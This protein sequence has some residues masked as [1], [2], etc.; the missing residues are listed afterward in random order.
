MGRDD[1]LEQQQWPVRQ[2]AAERV[3]D[4]A[5]GAFDPGEVFV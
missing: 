1:A 3:G 5:G 2:P 4:V